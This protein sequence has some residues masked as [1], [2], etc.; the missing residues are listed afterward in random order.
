MMSAGETCNITPTQKDMLLFEHTG[1][2]QP[3]LK[4]T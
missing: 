3:M 1:Q 2:S 4:Q